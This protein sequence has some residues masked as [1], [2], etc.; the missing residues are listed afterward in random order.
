[1]RINPFTD[2][3]PQIQ[4]RGDIKLIQNVFSVR[5][6]KTSRLSLIQ[7]FCDLSLLMYTVLPGDKVV[8]GISGQMYLNS[9]TK[10]LLQSQNVKRL[11]ELREGSVISCRESNP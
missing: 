8:M 7:C 2:T 11:F 4:A 5:S 10:K 9:R 3:D 1:M 6:F